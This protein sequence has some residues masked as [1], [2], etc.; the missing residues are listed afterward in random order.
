MRTRGWN[1]AAAIATLA[2]VI[3]IG[4]SSS[5]SVA[6]SPSAG[7]HVLLVPSEA[8]GT[9]AATPSTVLAEYASFDVVEASGD[10]VTSLVRAGAS[11]RD[12][13]RLVRLGSA[14]V[15]PLTDRAPLFRAPGSGLAS[16]EEALAIVQFVGPIKDEW[17]DALEKSGVRIV[18]YQA[19]NAYLVHGTQA[20]LLKAAGGNG[21]RAAVAYTAAD[22]LTGG[23]TL[24]GGDR[25]IGVSTLSGGDGSDARTDVDRRG[26]ENQDTTTVKGFSTAYADLSGAD[27]RALAADPGV[28]SIEPAPEPELHDE[29]SSQIIAGAIDPVTFVPTSA[30]YLTSF[31][32]ANGF[33]EAGMSDFVVD[34]TDTGIDKGVL[35]PQVGSHPDFFTGG[36][37]ANPTRIAYTNNG[38]TDPDTRDCI[39]HGSHVAST[40]TG[41][42]DGTGALVEDASSFNYGLGIAPRARVGSSKIFNCANAF[43]AGSLT[44]LV[45]SAY[46][47]GARVSN[48]SWGSDVRGAYTSTAREY[49]SLVRDAQPSVPGNQQIV[50]IV[51]AGNNGEPDTDGSVDDG[52]TATGL[53]TI[54]SPGTGKNVITV[55]AS[56][57]VRDTPGGC[58]EIAQADSARDVARFS[59]RGPTDDFRQKPDIMAPG[60]HIVSAK[61]QSTQFSGGGFCRVLGGTSTLY[62]ESNG[63]SMAAPQITGATALIRDWY[64]RTHGGGNVA[65]SPAMTKALLVNSATDLAGGDD[66]RRNS[67]DALNAP[68][69]NVPT[70]SQG[71]GRANLGTL[72]D[73]TTPRAVRD[74][75]NVLGASGESVTR[76]FAVDPT[77]PIK[78]TLAWSDAPGPTTG[79]S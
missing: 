76:T 68:N 9:L 25:P 19:Q 29:S 45:S 50:E 54:G 62:A 34:I 44:A 52:Y 72:F 60:T 6:Q 35:P 61:S 65:P 36:S 13:M 26:D 4:V 38:T 74:Q 73:A 59:S 33:T 32:D 14:D 67:V 2:G 1:S 18:T 77:K 17:Y 46:A 70:S 64:R 79:A 3:A 57:G 21:V 66:G 56:E 15:D 71:W 39:G 37:S 10:A 48:N 5:G 49:D 42:N 78:V 20:Q 30:D 40:A 7:S 12:D 58:R 47:K 63:T 43:D 22:K 53:D 27:V 51:S 69:A 55:G 75:T 16:G 28:I 23:V 11:V 31:S 8:A 41:Y 24:S